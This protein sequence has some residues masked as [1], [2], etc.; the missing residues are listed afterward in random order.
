M[1][2]FF[3]KKNPTKPKK[4]EREDPLGFFNHIHSVPNSKKLK[5]GPFRGEKFF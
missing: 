2:N 5:G 4:T 3:F 1:K